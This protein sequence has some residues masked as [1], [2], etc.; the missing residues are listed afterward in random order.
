MLNAFIEQPMAYLHSFQG[1]TIYGCSFA[2][3]CD[4]LYK[5][6]FRSRTLVEKWWQS[7]RV[8]I[9][10]PESEKK[11]DACTLYMTHTIDIEVFVNGK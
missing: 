9:T 5:G 1:V 10:Y 3:H 8:Y 4:P 7:A 11:V 2:T 6:V